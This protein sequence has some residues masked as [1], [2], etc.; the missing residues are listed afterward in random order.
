MFL[1]GGHQMNRE[2]RKKIEAKEADDKRKEKRR[3]ITKI[4]KMTI[5]TIIAMCAIVFSYLGV[6]Y[7][8]TYKEM[9]DEA[10]SIVNQVNKRTFV[11]LEPTRIIRPDGS[12]VRELSQIPYEYV[13]HSRLPENTKNAFVSIEDKNFYQH[14]GFDIKAILR[15]TKA[16]VEN[17]GE[18]TQGGST[19]TQ[20]LVKNTFLTHEQTYERK[21]KEI[22]ISVRLENKLSKDE[23]LGYYINN[24]YYGNGAYGI[25]TAA[26]YYFSDTISNLSLSEIAFLAAIPNNPTIFDPIENF[27]NTISRRN[28]IIENMYEDEKITEE[29][30]DKAIKEEIVLD[31][32][33]E[34]EYEP[35]SYEVSYL[36]SSATKILMDKE[37]FD[38]QVDF[39]NNSE[40]EQYEILLQEKFDELYSKL[41]AGGYEIVST[42][43]PEIQEELQ[44]NLNEGLQEFTEVQESG[45]Y[46]TQG[47]GVII[48]N[49]K[50]ELVAIVGG[51]TQE[52]I[53]NTYNRAHLSYRQPGSVIKPINV[54]GVEFDNGMIGSTKVNDAKEKDGPENFNFQY[55]GQTTARQALVRSVNTVP[56]ALMKERGVGVAHEYMKRMEFS[57]IVDEDDNASIAIGGFTYGTTP[58]EIASAYAT[59][60]NNGN[61]VRLTGISSIRFDG[62]IIYKDE[63]QERKIY[64]DGTAYLI[65]DILKEVIKQYGFQIEGGT[66]SAGKSG[67]TDENKDGWFSGYSPYYTGTIWVGN[68]NPEPLTNM[69]G[70]GQPGMIWSKTMNHIHKG[71]AIEDFKMPEGTK[72]MYVNI[73]TG[74]VSEN[75]QEGFTSYEPVPATYLQ[76]MQEMIA[77]EEEKAR[78]AEKEKQYAEQ[79]RK[80]D[81]LR[82]YGV[83]EEE[84]KGNQ[85]YLSS[86]ITQVKEMTIYNEMDYDY[87]KNVLSE[88]EIVLEIIKI[89]D[90][91]KEFNSMIETQYQEIDNKLKASLKKQ[92]MQE[93]EE[94]RARIEE[95]NRIKQEEKGRLEEEER[96]RIEEENRIKQ[97]EK[98]RL[99]EEKKREE[100]AELS[101]GEPESSEST[102]STESAESAEGS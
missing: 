48:D 95:E 45:L 97:E 71:L 15:A 76:I 92:R 88:A 58:L 64:N 39:V 26:N 72:M 86:L 59:L 20:Q 16:L 101:S 34:D 43:N 57:N 78:E 66:A 46:K 50:N 77:L 96:L 36:L 83:T 6:K 84:E 27:E 49:K 2:Q 11:R 93:E 42:I 56:F 17:N 94:E 38:F 52:N 47:S 14:E 74:E 100:Q 32:K 1:L 5:L 70:S 9:S 29:D 89:D 80:E 24:I 30:K 60:A 23:I 54:Y 98:A 19:I 37:G 51:R 85:E 18:I 87:A 10:E 3:K 21:I 35:E 41:R 25:E 69:W 31:I 33:P 8:P 79:I 65:T 44:K 75:A 99:E 22:L 68:D 4:A 61:Y 53:A 40:R 55:V 63:K 62:T 67:T 82:K 7:Y 90:K 91:R 81:F 28:L 73:Q 12:V 13:E 102:E